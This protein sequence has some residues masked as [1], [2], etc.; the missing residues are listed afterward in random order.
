MLKKAVHKYLIRLIIFIFMFPIVCNGGQMNQEAVQY[1]KISDVPESVWLKLGTKKIYF[2]HQSVGYNIVNGIQSILKE[3]PQIRLSIVEAN[4]P[5]T[6]KEGIIAH[7]RIGY[8]GDPKSKLDMFAFIAKSGGA[9]AADVMFFKFCYVD[10]EQKTN[11]PAM[12]EAYQKTFEK[13]KSNYP[14]TT[15]VHMTVPLT[16]LQEGPKVWVKKAIGR[17]LGGMLENI[18]RHE[19]NELLRTTYQGREPIVD[20]AAIE[21][22]FV[23]GRRATFDYEGQT[24]YHLVPAFTYDSGH[25]NETGAKMVA[26]QLLLTLAGT[27]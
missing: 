20:I 11:V 1:K 19:F 21:S 27:L 17:P 14:D 13:L 9:E 2:G 10:F 25:L 26:E 12:F 22:T 3:Y 8:N 7:S 5:G 6:Y 24:Y 23:D 4:D 15:F 18:K 16:T